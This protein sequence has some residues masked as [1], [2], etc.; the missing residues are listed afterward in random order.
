[1]WRMGPGQLRGL[2]PLFFFNNK[3]SGQGMV[4]DPLVSFPNK[5]PVSTGWW[6]QIFLE[7]SPLAGEMIQ[8]D[9]IWL[10]FFKSIIEPNDSNDSLELTPCNS[11]ISWR[12][13]SKSRSLEIKWFLLVFGILGEGRYQSTR[14]VGARGCCSCRNS[15]IWITW[16]WGWANAPSF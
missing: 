11:G 2:L 4:D 7:F 6:L 14:I 9:P 15:P 8:F 13:S 16:G 10:I 5:D 3:G 1:M 12:F